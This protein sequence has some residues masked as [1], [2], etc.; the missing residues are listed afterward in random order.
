MSRCEIPAVNAFDTVR[1]FLGEFRR[2]S[3]RSAVA[4]VTVRSDQRTSADEP[5][6]YGVSSRGG[7]GLHIRFHMLSADAPGGEAFGIVGVLHAMGV[8]EVLR[9]TL[10]AGLVRRAEILDRGACPAPMGNP[11]DAPFS[12]QRRDLFCAPT[13]CAS[14]PALPDTAVMIQNL[15]T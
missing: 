8:A 7:T 6:H 9:L 4:Q 2:V 14:E 1:R 3:H 12:C 15:R 11:W 10:F 13:A 5:A